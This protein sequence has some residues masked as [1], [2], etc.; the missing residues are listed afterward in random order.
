MYRRV[1]EKFGVE[2]DGWGCD[3]TAHI[4]DV[5]TKL[6]EL[7]LRKFRKMFTISLPTWNEKNPSTVIAFRRNGPRKGPD[8]LLD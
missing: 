1:V 5:T 8:W 7:L 6:S 3:L 2:R 4:R